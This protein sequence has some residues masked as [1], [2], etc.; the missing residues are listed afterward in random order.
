[1]ANAPP[2]VRDE[3]LSRM[4][5]QEA[6]K[7]DLA[8]Q[9][10]EKK[11]RKMLEKQR[12]LELERREDERV[13]REQEEIR[14][15][16]MIE[17][18]AQQKKEQDLAE[19]NRLAAEES[20]ARAE[21]ARKNAA[22]VMAMPNPKRDD[23]FSPKRSAMRTP[24]PAGG[25]PQITKSS[26]DGGGPT[27]S[28]SRREGSMTRLR[29]D[30]NDQHGALLRELNIQRETVMELRSQIE[31]FAK[32][33]AVGQNGNSNYYGVKRSGRDDVNSNYGGLHQQQNWAGGLHNQSSDKGTGNGFMQSIDMDDP[34]ELDN[35]LLDFVN[36]R[37]AYNPASRMPSL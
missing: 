1:M 33:G 9:M 35:L 27:N 31:M 32:G 22:E 5:K 12:K 28:G 19:A 36:K 24:P 11:R 20:K 13:R 30:L 18:R 7:S 16:Y 23:A 4:T 8:K 34:D 37:N 21:A 10:E 26:S 15:Q 17:H 14:T 25:Y 3:Y 29:R 2:E 6:L